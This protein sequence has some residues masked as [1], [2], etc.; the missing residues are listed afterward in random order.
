MPTHKLNTTH[1]LA[2]T[3][4][5]HTPYLFTHSLHIRTLTNSHMCTHSHI[6]TNT[7]THTFSYTHT[8]LSVSHSEKNTIL[9]VRR[10]RSTHF[11]YFTHFSVSIKWEGA[12]PGDL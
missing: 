10:L 4:T 6:L 8:L 9:D 3:L 7:C 5:H 1:T 2:Y 11:Y 12:E